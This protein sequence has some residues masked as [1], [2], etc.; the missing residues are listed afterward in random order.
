MANTLNTTVSIMDCQSLAD[1]LCGVKPHD[2][3]QPMIGAN[4]RRNIDTCST[5]G[6]CYQKRG[7]TS[8]D[9]GNQQNSVSITR[10]EKGRLE[11]MRWPSTAPAPQSGRVMLTASGAV[12]HNEA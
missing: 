12:S 9:I 1:Q 6:T 5:I 10:I 4:L 8:R 2:L 7:F 3:A 11:D